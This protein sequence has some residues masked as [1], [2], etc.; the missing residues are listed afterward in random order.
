MW[1]FARGVLIDNQLG[2]RRR[3]FGKVFAI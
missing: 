3:E 1:V 2:G